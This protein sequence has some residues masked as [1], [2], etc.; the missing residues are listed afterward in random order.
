MYISGYV[1]NNHDNDSQYHKP[2]NDY[3][4]L[5]MPTHAITVS[6]SIGIDIARD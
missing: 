3:S 1:C 4:R 6:I 2:Q 5:L